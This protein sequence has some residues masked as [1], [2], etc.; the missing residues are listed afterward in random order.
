MLSLLH[1][2]HSSNQVRLEFCCECECSTAPMCVLGEGRGEK[3]REEVFED[4]VV[5][6]A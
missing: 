4:L 5:H 6:K 1:L 2:A 3:R